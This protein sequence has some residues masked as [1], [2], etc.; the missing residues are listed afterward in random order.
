MSTFPNETFNLNFNIEELFTSE[1]VN[2]K[3][4]EDFFQNSIIW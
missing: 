3:T 1:N 4:F 2:F